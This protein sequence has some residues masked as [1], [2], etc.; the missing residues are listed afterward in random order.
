MKKDNLKTGMVVEM[1]DGCRGVVLKTDYGMWILLIGENTDEFCSTYGMREDMTYVNDSNCDIM[2]VF[3]PGMTTLE[4]MRYLDNP[5]WERM[6]HNEITGETEKKLK[7]IAQQLEMSCETI[8]EIL[9]GGET[10]GSSD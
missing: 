6:E 1:R 4:D 5:V 3:S 2:Q 7:E 9:K 8:K 10:N